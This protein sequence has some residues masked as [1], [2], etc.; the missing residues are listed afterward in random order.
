MFFHRFNITAIKSKRDRPGGEGFS[1]PAAGSLPT[2]WV[3]KMEEP[4]TLQPLK[5]SSWK[6]NTS[7]TSP[8]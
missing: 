7:R 1:L 4:P 6:Q 3:Q 2:R 5:N 8:H